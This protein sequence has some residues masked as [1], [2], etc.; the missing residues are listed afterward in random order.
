MCVCV[1]LSMVL[2]SVSMFVYALFPART[3]VR[4]FVCVLA[5]VFTY[6]HIFPPSVSWK[7]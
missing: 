7:E 5:C 3:C 4:M 2:L 1:C 6:L